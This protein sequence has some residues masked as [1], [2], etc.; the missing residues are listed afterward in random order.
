MRIL[1]AL[2]CLLA[3]PFSRAAEPLPLT[4]LQVLDLSGP[5]RD[6][7]NEFLTGARVYF[8]YINTRG[9][10]QGRKISHV[11]ADDQGLPA[12]TL[13]LT[14]QWVAQ[15]KPVALFGY[16][17]ADNVD[18]VMSDRQLRTNGLAMVG[19]YSGLRRA[20]WPNLFA[21]RAGFDDEIRRIL[22]MTTQLGMSRIGLFC[23]TDS[24]GKAASELVI[25]Q[26]AAN[27][28]PPV[29]RQLFH[30]TVHVRGAAQNMARQAPQAVILAAPTLASALFAREMQAELPGTRFFALSSVNH[31]TLL[32]LLGPKDA[33]GIAVT[34]LTPSPFNP[35]TPIARDYVR[36][37]KQF[38][39]EPVSY[40]S[41]EGYIAARVLVEGLRNARPGQ[42]GPLF[43]GLHSLDL[44]GYSLNLDPGNGPASRFVDLL[45]FSGQGRLLN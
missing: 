29:S 17:G 15:A 18:A 21:V 13:A 20:E 31:Q 1:L 27:R 23:G 4:V 9:G 38:R 37:M 12:N 3:S 41:L 26:A 8:D 40:A 33:Q 11:V 34:A 36:H 14:R 5:Q 16:L 25:L 28:L 35:L 44:G 10:I 45:V 30:A 43:A 32:E 6:T 19:P 7:G 39:D 2:A 22:K 24:L 42:P